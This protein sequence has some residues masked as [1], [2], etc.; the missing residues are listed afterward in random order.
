[1]VLLTAPTARV[2]VNLGMKMPSWYDIKGFAVDEINFTKSHGI[3]EIKSN[4]LM[5]IQWIEQ[6]IK[7]LSGN[8]KKVFI[9]GF[10]QGS[11]MALYNGLSFNKPLGGIISLSGYLFPI[12]EIHKE[13]E[14]TPIFISHGLDD[15]LI[16]IKQ[17][18]SSFKKIMTGDRKIT[19]LWEPEMAHAINDN[20]IQGVKKFVSAVTSEK[21][22]EL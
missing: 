12:T 2:T 20:V 5:I 13:N 3:D 4:S 9:G 19:T 7:E 1:M 22:G 8:S 16:P 6:E 14:K 17:A 15:P 21:S 10:S 18:Q 11:S